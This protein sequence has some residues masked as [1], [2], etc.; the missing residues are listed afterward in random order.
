MTR[1]FVVVIIVA[2]ALAG[3][4]NT[5]AQKRPHDQLMKEV[6]ATFASLR[7]NLDANAASAAAEDASKLALLFQETESFWTPFKTKDAIEAAR[8]AREAAASVSKSAKAGS[9]AKAQTAYA[10]IGKYCTACH[11]THREQMPDKT[12]RIKP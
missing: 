2:A 10:E 12:Y 11:N 5:L 4:A 8:G 9:I 3:A 1:L 7:R 6:G